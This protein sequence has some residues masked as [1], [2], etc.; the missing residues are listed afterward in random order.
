MSAL[1]LFSP[2]FV[3]PSGLHFISISTSISLPQVPTSIFV[4]SRNEEQKLH[5]RSSNPKNDIQFVEFSV[6]LPPVQVLKPVF[7]FEIQVGNELSDPGNLKNDVHIALTQ[8]KI[9]T[10]LLFHYLNINSWLK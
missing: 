10:S 3:S 7:Q 9:F 2:H 8:F 1:V 6:P 4:S 5:K